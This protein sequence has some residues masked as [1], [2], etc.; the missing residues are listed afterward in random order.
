MRR[1][2]VKLQWG[3]VVLERLASVFCEVAGV[4]DSSLFSFLSVFCPEG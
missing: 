1:C 2:I 3:E 4:G